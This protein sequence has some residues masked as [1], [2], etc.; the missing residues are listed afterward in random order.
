M[1]LFVCSG[2]FALMLAAVL[3]VVSLPTF[4]QA[5]HYLHAAC[6]TK[7]MTK[8]DT[9]TKAALPISSSFVLLSFLKSF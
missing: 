3:Q 9:D 5:G 8:P 4:Y 7:S 6:G 1:L 2:F